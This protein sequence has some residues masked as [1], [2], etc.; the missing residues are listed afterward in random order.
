MTTAAAIE[1]EAGRLKRTTLSAEISTSYPTMT[2]ISTTAA[3]AA[4]DPPE[5]ALRLEVGTLAA[6]VIWAGGD[7]LGAAA[8][9]MEDP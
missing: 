6:M 3:A 8:N 1:D 5:G 4:A 9:S 2:T 7:L